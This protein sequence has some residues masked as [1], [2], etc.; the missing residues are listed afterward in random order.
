M[1]FNEDIEGNKFNN[2][3][4]FNFNYRSHIQGF[5][6]VF[7]VAIID[8]NRWPYDMKG[9]FEYEQDKRLFIQCRQFI[10]NQV[11]KYYKPTEDQSDPLI[12]NVGPDGPDDPR[13]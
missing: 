8:C 13:N 5:Y 6:S 7:K 2:G 12:D 9:Q 11:E 1:Y 10:R 4:Y 3:N